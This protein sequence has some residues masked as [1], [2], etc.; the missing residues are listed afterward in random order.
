M[1]KETVN[2]G[3][4][5]VNFN[6]AVY[7]LNAIKK[8]A[9]KFGCHFYFLIEEH[10]RL[11]EVW[12]IPKNCCESPCACIREF[13]DEVLDQELRQRVTAEMAGIRNLLLAQAFSAT[14]RVDCASAIRLQP[15]LC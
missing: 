1:L 14:S 15:P 2:D 7:G 11:T 10:D 8:A 4:Q 6:A 5:V 13:C 9:Y 3:T 12:L